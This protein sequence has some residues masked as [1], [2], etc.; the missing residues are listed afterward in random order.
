[1]NIER[2]RQW[3]LLHQLAASIRCTATFRNYSPHYRAV[4]WQTSFSMKSGHVCMCTLD[5]ITHFETMLPQKLTK[6]RV[7]KA[8][9]QADTY[10]YPMN[11]AYAGNL[12]FGRCD[13]S[14]GF[15]T[16]LWFDNLIQHMYVKNVRQ[17]SALSKPILHT[18]HW[19][20]MRA[21]C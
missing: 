15:D 10:A 17:W 12:A 11:N 7:R 8:N 1:M 19:Y 16:L 18:Y 3:W 5:C 2:A 21:L 20:K 4:A 13:S 9:A 6:L 14:G